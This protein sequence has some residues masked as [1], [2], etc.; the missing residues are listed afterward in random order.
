MVHRYT[1]H[2]YPQ[3]IRDRI[4]DN[5]AHYSASSLLYNRMLSIADTY[6]DNGRGGTAETFGGPASY[7][8]NGSVVYYLRRDA[9]FS[10][11]GVSYFTYDGEPR[12]GEHAAT[13]NAAQSTQSRK[14][15]GARVDET[16]LLELFNALAVNNKYCAELQRIG[17]KIVRR[18]ADG[19]PVPDTSVA[20]T[21]TINNDTNFFEVAAFTADNVR[22]NRNFYYV[23][24]G[25]S[26]KLDSRDPQLEGLMFPV[27]FMFNEYGY[28]GRAKGIAKVG[29]N[30][31][32]RARFLIP[33]E[34]WEFYCDENVPGWDGLDERAGLRP[35]NPV[36]RFQVLSRL[37]QAFAVESV[38]R[39]QDWRLK[40]HRGV[41]KATIFGHKHSENTGDGEEP[42][43]NDG[44]EEVDLH[45][46]V[47]QALPS[48]AA[49]THP[50]ITA[51]TA[52]LIDSETTTAVPAPAAAPSTDVDTDLPV[53]YIAEEEELHDAPALDPERETFSNS[54]PSFLSQSYVGSPRHL[55]ALAKNA[56]VIVS[57]L[58]P[59]S[60]FITLTCDVDDPAIR[61]RLL[62]GQTAYDRP[63]LVVQVFR[64][65]LRAFLH[66]LRNGKYLGG[67]TVYIMHVIEYQHRGL[68]H[69]HIVAQISDVPQDVAGR[70]AWIEEH[71]QARYPGPDEPPDP[72][73]EHLITTFQIHHCST[74][75]NGCIDKAGKVMH[76]FD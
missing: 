57:D 59:P 62:K 13:V 52:M 50:T 61:Y 30:E 19:T 60:V 41:G 8:V 58:G 43:E 2:P 65:Q 33:E 32:M 53:H 73:Y 76:T 68:P 5:V 49:V 28:D 37:G 45:E 70:L 67:K 55:K 10:S 27:L 74:A 48:P 26:T 24:K 72:D 4:V 46:S 66:N 64:A 11:N 14:R 18:A 3:N 42:I 20:L 51:T 36:N 40:W 22:G 21:A 31:Y 25:I 38:S 75:A 12:L 23:L 56:L 47:A 34:Q 15:Y 63:E 16:E 1:L 17:S 7:T 69:A 6:I 39:A 54:S 9:M 71:I 44:E 35:V 29:F